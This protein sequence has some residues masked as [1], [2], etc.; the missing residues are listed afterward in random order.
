ITLVSGNSSF[1]KIENVEV[2]Q[3]GVMLNSAFYTYGNVSGGWGITFIPEP[4][5]FGL[6]AG[7]LALALVA[8][9]RRRR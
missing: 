3:N 4:S 8:S 5:A 2:L 9:R 1:D 6:L 7:T